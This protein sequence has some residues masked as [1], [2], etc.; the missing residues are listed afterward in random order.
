MSRRKPSIAV[1]YHFFPPDYIVSAVHYGDLCSGLASRGWQVNVYP[2][3]W[4]SHESS[5]RFAPWEKGQGVTIRRIW[6]P[7]LRQ[8]SGAGRFL[9]AAW[10]IFR[11]SLLSLTLKPRPDVLL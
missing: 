7:N 10:M 4:S 2:C 5:V 1:L 6:L 11:W 3:I 8:A 9:N